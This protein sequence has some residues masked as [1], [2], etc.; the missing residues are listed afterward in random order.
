MVDNTFKQM[1][2]DIVGKEF[3]DSFRQNNTDD[4]IDMFR[5]FEK[6]NHGGN[7][8]FTTG[9]IKILPSFLE[10]YKEEKGT[11]ISKRILET[12]YA[13][14]LKLARDKV[15]I[16]EDLFQSFFDPANEKIIHYISEI[17]SNSEVK[18][19]KVILMVGSFS[20]FGI[21]Q[22]AIRKAFPECCVLVPLQAGL[23]V[24]KGAVLFGHSVK[25][26]DDKPSF[27]EEGDNRLVDALDNTKLNTTTKDKRSKSATDRRHRRCSIL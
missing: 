13:K 4:Y 22:D 26:E 11:D 7:N 2:I 3:M 18:G 6:K 15:Q 1:F 16:N 12:Q 25:S 19:T 5:T 8:F 20:E 27:L 21:V 24:L 23:A 17:L 10:K 9:K 14:S